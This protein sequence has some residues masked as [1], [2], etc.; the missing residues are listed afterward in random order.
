ME[1]MDIF[2]DDAFSL[3]SMTAAINNIDHVPGRAGELCFVGV[4]EGIATTTASIES[5]DQALTLIQTSQRG[6]PAPKETSD[7]AKLR[8]VNVPQIK[9]EDT[10]GAHQIQGVRQFGTTD[11]L[12]GVQDVVN[13]RMGK[14][15]QRHDLTIE[16]HR[17]GALKGLIK[18][19]DGSSL[20]N[21][22]SLFDITN[23][24]SAVGGG[25]T[26]AAPKIFQYDLD[27]PSEDSEDIR[28]KNMEVIR[29]IKRHAKLILPGGF[30]IHAFCGDTF[31]DELISRE[32]VKAVY[33]NTSEQL[34]RLGKNYEFGIFEFGGIIFENYQGTDDNSTVAIAADEARVFL[35]GVP[36]LYAE[37]FAPA[38]FMETVNTIGLPRYAKLAPDTRFNQFV[39]LHT[40]QNPLPLCLR[41]QTLVTLK[42]AG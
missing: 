24:N 17:L 15:S 26:D 12:V 11:Q 31:F 33:Q 37:Y 32:D 38:D 21:L 2:N 8:S 13:T 16:H 9:L 34:A 41:P 6:S 3:I 42:A 36:G 28:V 29:W 30:K 27:S 22:F 1:M 7:K 23:D 25:S 4:G 18:D 10:I 39:E 19:A 35:T 14:M 5:R 40:Q 20:V